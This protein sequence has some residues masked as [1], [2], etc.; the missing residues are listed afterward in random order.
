MASNHKVG[1]VYRHNYDNVAEEFGW[2]TLNESLPA[3]LSAIDGETAKL[4]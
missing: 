4:E 2:R 1:N 3:L